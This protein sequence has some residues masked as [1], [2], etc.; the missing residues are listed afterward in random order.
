MLFLTTNINEY[1]T[2]CIFILVNEFDI[3]SLRKKFINNFLLSMYVDV[4]R[5]PY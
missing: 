5:F 1:V 2:L 4:Y 3:F